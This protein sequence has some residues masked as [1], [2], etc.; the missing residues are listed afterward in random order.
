MYLL[1]KEGKIIQKDFSAGD[2]PR[3]LEEGN[4]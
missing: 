3:F 4:R 1:D 2:L